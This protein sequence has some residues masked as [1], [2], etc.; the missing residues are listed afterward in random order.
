MLCC[1]FDHYHEPPSHARPP[2]AP[3]LGGEYGAPVDIWSLGCLTCVI[4]VVVVVPPAAATPPPPHPPAG[5]SRN[6]SQRRAR[7]AG[8]PAF[9][10][11][12]P[13]GGD[14][15]ALPRPFRPLFAPFT[16]LVA[17]MMT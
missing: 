10:D 13:S 12:G 16:S 4:V 17:A 6:V 7:A 14:S 11:C 15:L 8:A 1:V 2:P 9:I 5:A 3:K